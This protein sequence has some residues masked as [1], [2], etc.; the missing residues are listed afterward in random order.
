MRL[1]VLFR[2][3]ALITILIIF[4]FGCAP[5]I[6]KESVFDTPENHYIQ[7]FKLLEEGKLVS[8]EEHFKRAR[9]LDKKDP[10]SY[11]GMALLHMKKENFKEAYKEVNRGISRDKKF[12]DAYVT[13]GRI[14]TAERKGSKWL[15]R[16][17]KVYEDGLKVSLGNE[18]VFFYMGESYTAAYEFN[19]AGNAYSQVIAKKGSYADRANRRYET[20]QKIQRAAPG[21]PHGKEI[22]LIEEIDRADLTVLFLEEL[23]LKEVLEKRRPKYFNTQFKAFQEGGGSQ[24]KPT[25]KDIR[26]HWAKTWIQDIIA[27]QVSGLEL[28][29][30]DQ[31]KPDQNIARVNFA[32]I[33]QGLIILI[34]NDQSLATKYIGET[35]HFPDVRSDHFA[36]NA[37][38]LC[39]DRGFMSADKITGAFKMDKTVSGAD[40]LLSI[41]E[42]QNA[43]SLSF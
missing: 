23:K 16:A 27:L 24:K 10:C 26:N 4:V 30:G 5:G 3:S 6:K 34:S 21:T 2:W 19:N 38:N 39:V 32:M 18:M 1:K 37:I 25:A 20:I 17:I 42:L 9:G 43:L 13:K 41:R 31:F 33:L 11:V 22:A 8:A 35:S 15:N 36:Y 14:I 28:F 7:G 29:P 40:A 12:I